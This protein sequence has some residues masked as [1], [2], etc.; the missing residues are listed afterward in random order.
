MLTIDVPSD[1]ESRLKDAAVASG[2]SMDVLVLDAIIE[3]LE[4]VEDIA[5]AEREL[6]R[7]QAGEPTI[8]LDEVLAKHGLAR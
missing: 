4:N 7:V 1:V 8:P 5:A 3:H 6:E 2:K